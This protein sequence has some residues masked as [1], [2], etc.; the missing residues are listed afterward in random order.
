[1]LEYL[2]SSYHSRTKELEGI[3]IIKR[4]ELGTFQNF[5]K[6]VIRLNK[7]TIL[8]LL[9]PLFSP[10][11]FRFSTSLWFCRSFA[12]KK[13]YLLA[14]QTSFEYAIIFD[15]LTSPFYFHYIEPVLGKH[16]I[17]HVPTR[18]RQSSQS[19]IEKSI[20]HHI[21]TSWLKSVSI[22]HT[23]QSETR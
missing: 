13:P 2:I 23:S 20:N 22:E 11:S 6:P 17:F 9:L 21:H 1:M 5:E 7:L 3:K 19:R 8:S 4:S 16:Y 14:L 10:F 15:F 12:E 18:I